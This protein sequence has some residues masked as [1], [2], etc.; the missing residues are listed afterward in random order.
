MK[1]RLAAALLAIALATAFPVESGAAHAAAD[2]PAAR[3]LAGISNQGR[4]KRQPYVTAGDRSFLIGTQDG[5]FP[6]M[7]WHVTG[8]MGGLWLP[9]VKLLDGFRARIADVDTDEERVLAES[10]AMVVYPYANRFLYGRVLDSVDVERVEF[11]P[12]GKPGLVIEYL[13][14]NASDRVRRLRF[15]WSVKTDLRP[16]WHADRL[17]IRDNQ[18]T[19]KWRQDDGI[20]V[21]RDIGNSW[22]C[23]WGAPSSV[24]AG[25]V[26]Q[27]DPILSNGRGVSA[28]SSH[29]VTVGAR[30]TATLT[31]IV[32]GS[33]TGESDAIAAY[34]ELA[35]RHVALLAEKTARFRSIVE[36]ARIR[37]PDRRLQEV[38]DWTRINMEWLVREIPG[39]GRGLSGGY[40]EYPWWFGTETYSLQALMATGDFELVRQTLRLLWSHSE[41]VNGNGRIPHEITADGAVAHAGNAQETAQ[42]ILTLGK[43]FE[44][45]GDREFAREMYPAM[46][47]GIDWLLGERDRDRDL[48]PEGYG[49]MEVSSLDAELIDVPVY[50]QQALEATAHIADALDDAAARQR[51]LQLASDM[52]ERINQRFWIEREGTYADF[53]GSK[54]DAVSA[55]EGA[56]RQIRLKGQHELTRRD[57]DSIAH[58]ERL[59]TE[60]SAM[61]VAERAWITNENWVIA[62]P[63]ETGIAPRE[64]AIPLLDKIRREKSGDYGPWLSAVEQQAMMTISTGVQAV[65]EGKYGRTAEAMWY[66]NKIVETFNRVTPGS[67]SEM[68]PDDG[69]FTIAWTGYG[70]VLP[71]IEHVFGIQPAAANKTIVFE[72]HLPAGWEDIRIEDLPVG[73]NLVSFSRTRMGRDIVY[74][75]EARE[76]G[77]TFILR[78]KASPEARY[79]L[80]GKPVR[81]SPSGIRMEG[82]K[83]RL[84]ISTRRHGMNSRDSSRMH[85][86]TGFGSSH[87][88]S[89][90]QHSSKT[91]Q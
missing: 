81:P 79:L 29:A 70:I 39:V 67:I 56:I 47:Q 1:T 13:F 48:F 82:R 41:K 59:K 71:L 49:I 66:V 72:P 3:I 6:D 61:P 46:Q 40:M 87:L 14:R 75:V 90:S 36:R 42:F 27:P 19:V 86:S 2:D 74:E 34:D 33:T 43:L 54:S 30:G 53:Y 52:K 83:N 24:D 16:A 88:P 73:T 25:R 26:W 32:A 63:M 44:W 80:N 35:T 69:C 37:I 55:A 4:N 60:F 28:T 58:Y 23:V 64:R 11:S 12:D 10:A 78:E 68:M 77:W 7:G 89:T 8:E 91:E 31:F 62:T 21:A 57:R 5:N 17:G 65:A 22:Y 15:Q 45:T 38:Y 50:A 84:L 9:P 85:A 76:N 51:Y 20:F 18:D